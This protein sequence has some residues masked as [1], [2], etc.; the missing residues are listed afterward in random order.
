MINWRN[1]KEVGTPTNVDISYLVTDGTDI[2][3]SDIYGRTDYNNG[4][5]LPKFHFKGWSGDEFT[6]EDNECCS[7]ERVFDMTPT[8]WCPTYEINLPK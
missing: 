6:Y 4:V 1:I 8:H 3:T 2:S 5:I 7:G